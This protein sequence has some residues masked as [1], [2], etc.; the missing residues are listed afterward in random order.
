MAIM[1]P[2]ISAITTL[3]LD[4]SSLPGSMLFSDP[5]SNVC[6]VW[7]VVELPVMH[8]LALAVEFTC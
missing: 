6:V 7:N 8:Q 5:M 3:A 2:M 1:N 4:A